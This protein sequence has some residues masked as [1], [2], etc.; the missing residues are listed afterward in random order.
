LLYAGARQGY[1]NFS[2]FRA[3]VSSSH[4]LKDDFNV[5]AFGGGKFDSVEI[6]LIE[7]SDISA[8]KVVPISGSD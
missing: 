6:K 3:A 5:I 7:D 1:K 8:E 4:K 2:G